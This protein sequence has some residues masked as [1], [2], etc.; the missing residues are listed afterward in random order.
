MKLFKKKS[1]SSVKD[2]SQAQGSSGGA[3][4]KEKLDSIPP[5]QCPPDDPDCTPGTQAGSQSPEQADAQSKGSASTGNAPDISQPETG[6]ETLEPVAD[7]AADGSGQNQ[8]PSFDDTTTTSKAPSQADNALSGDT[9]AARPAEETDRPDARSQEAFGEKTGASEAP[10]DNEA[11]GEASGDEQVG[12]RSKPLATSSS[13]SS[14]EL[15]SGR[16]SSSADLLGDSAQSSSASSGVEELPDFQ[17]EAFDLEHL[18]EELSQPVIKERQG[19][20]VKELFVE[21][22]KYQEL[23]MLLDDS[24]RTMGQELDVQ[25][26]IFDNEQ[27][28]GEKCSELNKRYGALYE[29]LSEVISKISSS[30]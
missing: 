7:K 3:D 1:S 21:K 8:P 12:M 28:L 30:E 18:K 22:R 9:S 11:V 20:F 19:A 10:A 26:S 2:A 13:Q 27:K 6:A 16:S 14:N 17:S 25:K 23:L 24:K 15:Q 4:V 5:V 29:S